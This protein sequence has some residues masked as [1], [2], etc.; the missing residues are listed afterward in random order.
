MPRSGATSRAGST[1]AGLLQ[2]GGTAIYGVVQPGVTRICQPAL[3]VT[4]VVDKPP[5]VGYSVV[6]EGQPFALT[7]DTVL[8]TVALGGTAASVQVVEHALSLAIPPCF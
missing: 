5:R 6:L 2:T 7:G 4:S 8:T 1:Q 3:G